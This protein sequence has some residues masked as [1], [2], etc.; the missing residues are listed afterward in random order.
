MAHPFFAPQVAATLEDL[1]EIAGGKLT[2]LRRF[3]VT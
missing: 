1:V 2:D 3:S